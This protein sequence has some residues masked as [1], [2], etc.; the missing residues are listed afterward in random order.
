MC[1]FCDMEVLNMGKSKEDKA[2]EKAYED[3]KRFERNKHKDRNDL[4]TFFVGLLMFGGGLFM[5]LQ[6]VE[7]S[8]GWGGFGGSFFRIGSYSLPNGLIML[9]I[10]IGIGMLFVMDRKI[11]GGIV[12]SLGIVIFL[13]S[14]IM[15]VHLHWLRTSAYVFVI[16]FGLVAAGGGMMMRVLF[17]KD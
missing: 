14:I 8:S 2:L 9:P 16:M 11:F 6:N 17:R 12:L 5:I 1:I 10:I 13:L 7:V 4:L 3:L 15:S